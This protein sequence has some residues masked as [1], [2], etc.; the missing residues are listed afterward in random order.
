MSALQSPPGTRQS[1]QTASLFALTLQIPLDLL[2]HM[3]QGAE[4][5]AQQ[6]RPIAEPSLGFGPTQI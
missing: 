2:D 1:Q 3:V 5:L 6:C 4:Q